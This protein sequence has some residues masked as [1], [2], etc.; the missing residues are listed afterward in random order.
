MCPTFCRILLDISNIIQRTL[1][2]NVHSCDKIDP[3]G[4]AIIILLRQR[5]KITKIW[6]DIMNEYRF[7]EMCWV[8]SDPWFYVLSSNILLCIEKLRP[9]KLIVENHRM[10]GNSDKYRMFLFRI[11]IVSDRIML[12]KLR[13]SGIPSHVRHG[14]SGQVNIPGYVVIV[15]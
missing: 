11:R 5:N 8:Y 12:P 10:C 3:A 1:E 13:I 6:I 9:I 7:F 4:Y 15:L 14:I 2:K